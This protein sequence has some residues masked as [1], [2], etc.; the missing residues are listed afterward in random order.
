MRARNREQGLRWRRLV[1]RT[2]P[3]DALIP[4]ILDEVRH[5]LVRPRAVP[6]PTP[7]TA[8][9]SASSRW[10]RRHQAPVQANRYRRQ[11]KARLLNWSQ[12]VGLEY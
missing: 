11:A 2:P 12:R 8:F 1:Q 6:Q 9:A 7:P 5:L 3:A 4:L 10:H